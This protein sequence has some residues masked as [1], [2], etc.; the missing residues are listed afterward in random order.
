MYQAVKELMAKLLRGAGHCSGATAVEYAV[1]LGLILL[2]CMGAA[3]AIGSGWNTVVFA[4]LA[5]GIKM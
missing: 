1:L 5:D 3:K 4:K 2:V